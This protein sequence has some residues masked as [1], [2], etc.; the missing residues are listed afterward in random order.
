[1]FEI[2]LRSGVPPHM[3]Q[4]P[5]P[6]SEAEAVG[7]KPVAN[8]ANT[9]INDL[10]KRFVVLF[11]LRFI[12]QSSFSCPNIHLPSAYCLPLLIQVDLQII[13]IQFRQ[14]ATEDSRRSLP[15]R[16]RIYA[17]H[18]PRRRFCVARQPHFSPRTY[19]TI[20]KILHFKLHAVPSVRFPR[21]RNSGGAGIFPL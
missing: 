13:E 11:P 18:H 21:Q 19:L 16:N 3:G 8:K 6:G 10:F 7:S 5:L 2:M 17:F 1:M 12:V 15:I 9:S 20:R 4:S 14:R